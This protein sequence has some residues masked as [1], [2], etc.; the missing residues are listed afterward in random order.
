MQ[1]EFLLYSRSE[2]TAPMQKNIFVF[3]WGWFELSRWNTGVWDKWGYVAMKLTLSLLFLILLPDTRHWL[4]SQ[5]SSIV[6]LQGTIFSNQFTWLAQ[7][8]A[9]TWDL[10]LQFYREI[11]KYTVCAIS[12]EHLWRKD[13]ERE[14]CDCDVTSL[15]LWKYRKCMMLPLV[16]VLYRFCT[17]NIVHSYAESSYSIASPLFTVF[18][19][20]KCVC[21]NS[22]RFCY[23][24]NT[25]Q[26]FK[27]IIYLSIHLEKYNTSYLA[28]A[29]AYKKKSY[30]VM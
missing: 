20:L 1:C 26:G 15:S 22:K 3:F 21:T 30:Q 18:I 9:M 5:C 14:S 10:R 13:E 28:F 19:V 11:R 25:I 17:V 2:V 24:W 23:I 16:F 8:D 12:L 29:F 4:T 27:T 6:L 7:V